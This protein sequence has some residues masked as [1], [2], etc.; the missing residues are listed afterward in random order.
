MWK[1]W[2][3]Q[4]SAREGSGGGGKVEMEE[5]EGVGDEG[6]ESRRVW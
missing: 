5:S 4:D 1:C 2:P 6:T 3:L